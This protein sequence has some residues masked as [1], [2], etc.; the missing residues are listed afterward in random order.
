MRFVIVFA[1]L[2]AGCDMAP[3]ESLT[4]DALRNQL[5]DK[6]LTMQLVSAPKPGKILMRV[7]ANGT[8]NVTLRG[9]TRAYAWR[10]RQGRFCT[11]N[12]VGGQSIPATEECAVVTFEGN[13][14]TM[15]QV[16]STTGSGDLL[17]GRMAPL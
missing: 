16:T 15:Q 12:L 6:R 9:E 14:V 5:A 10:I 4:D 17:K 13:V 3:D 11:Y 2:I 1:L 8:M 7:N